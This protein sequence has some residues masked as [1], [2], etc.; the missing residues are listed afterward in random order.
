MAGG[1]LGAI[2]TGLT[3]DADQAAG[4]I[5]ESVA[6]ISEQT[7]DNEEANLTRILENEAQTAKAFTDIGERPGALGT[8][9]SEVRPGASTGVPE[10]PVPGQSGGS[11]RPRVDDS[12]RSW[13][14]ND[15]WAQD[16]Y[17]NIRN[18]DDVSAVANNL[19]DAPRLDGSTGFSTA[20]I[21][22]IKSHV[23]EEEHPLSGDQGGI[24]NSRF[25]ASPDIAEA[26]L[27]LRSGNYQ[28]EDLTLLEHESAEHQYWQQNPGAIYSEAH[29]AANQVARW[30]TIVP[31]PT[32]EDYNAAWE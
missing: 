23:F 21:Q 32:Y 22:A 19:R 31:P 20:E 11:A 3:E 16:A 27:R 7:A 25:D 30:E 26:W 6:R 5:A 18:S 9:A 14:R 12:L 29:Q 10:Q 15:Q 1:E 17:E 8:P 2:F 4:N 13:E 28:P 24:V